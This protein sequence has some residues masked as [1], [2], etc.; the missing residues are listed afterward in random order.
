MAS[1][2]LSRTSTSSTTSPVKKQNVPWF[3]MPKDTPLPWHVLSAPWPT[4][5][6]SLL[7][8]VVSKRSPCP[9][10]S[11]VV[12]LTSHASHQQPSILISSGLLAMTS[13]YSAHEDSLRVLIRHTGDVF[14]TSPK[15]T[16]S[17]SR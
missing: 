15:P 1:L 16:P 12:Q 10:S 17:C 14:W 8:P 6:F 5:S 9:T 7:L 4:P 11:G 2:A 3:S 13:P